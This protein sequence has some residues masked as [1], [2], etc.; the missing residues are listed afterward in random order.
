MDFYKFRA[1]I[2][3]HGVYEIGESTDKTQ[4]TFTLRDGQ[5]FA[6]YTTEIEVDADNIGDG[7][8]FEQ[9]EIRYMEGIEL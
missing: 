2:L 5:R 6:L 3:E 8:T 4:L 7:R 9:S 1:R